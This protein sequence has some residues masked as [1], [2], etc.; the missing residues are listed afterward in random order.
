MPKTCFPYTNPTK[1]I[2]KKNKKKLQQNEIAIEENM[3]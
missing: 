3:Q 1:I 2:Q